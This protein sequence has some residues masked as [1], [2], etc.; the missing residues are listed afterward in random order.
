M[1]H[2]DCTVLVSDHLLVLFL[3]GIVQTRQFII[4]A[5]EWSVLCS[6]CS[7]AVT[8][9]TVAVNVVKLPHPTSN[10]PL[11]YL[12]SCLLQQPSCAPCCEEQCP[13][14]GRGKSRVSF[15]YVAFRRVLTRAKL[16][17]PQTGFLGGKGFFFSGG[18]WMALGKWS[19]G[20]QLS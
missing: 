4:P 12:H 9:K 20:L 6:L 1:R 11:S 8:R 3:R 5:S 13:S 17:C 18:G 19:A 14:V 7:V 15:D 16:G 10:L 2:V